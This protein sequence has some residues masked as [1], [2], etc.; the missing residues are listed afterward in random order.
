MYRTIGLLAVAV[1][2]SWLGGCRQQTSSTASAPE[3][4]AGSEAATACNC[5]DAIAVIDLN[6]VAEE[7]GARQKIS[8]SLRQRE[9]E[10]VGQLN[11]FREELDRRVDEIR[12][13][14]GSDLN[15][16]VQTDL[17][18]LMTENQARISLQAQAAQAQLTTHHANLK[19]QLLNQVR[20]VAWQIAKSHGLS[21]VMTTGQVYAAAP[22]RDITTEVVQEIRRLNEA[23]ST[24]VSPLL[25]D[26]GVRIAEMPGG[27]D[28][29]PR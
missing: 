6:I 3:G 16:A 17:E 29:L 8:E 20:P 21:I 19:Q 11:S 28:F 26:S 13:K 18:K 2:S 7:I 10:L 1:I 24:S 5:A 23:E 25:L 27:G 9:T 12:V 4:T 22:E 14:S 15:Q